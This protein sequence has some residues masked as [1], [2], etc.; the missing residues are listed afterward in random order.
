MLYAF[1]DFNHSFNFEQI[2]ETSEAMESAEAPMLNKVL[3]EC[4]I[5]IYIEGKPGS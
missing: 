2:F 4:V 3:T 1:K 5:K